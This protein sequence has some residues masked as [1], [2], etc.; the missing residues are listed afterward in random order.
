MVVIVK[1]LSRYMTT[2]YLDPEGNSTLPAL[3]HVRP[4][5]VVLQ[6]LC[7]SLKQGVEDQKSSRMLY[8]I[9]NRQY[10]DNGKENGACYSI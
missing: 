6:R 5:A 10:R 9:G 8:Y 1:V 2:R 7:Q 4:G 3:R